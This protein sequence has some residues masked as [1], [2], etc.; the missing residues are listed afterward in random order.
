[1]HTLTIG[2]SLPKRALYEQIAREAAAL[3]DGESDAIANFANLAA[4]LYHSLPDVNWAG[5]YL[6]K[7]DTLIVGPFQG[8]PACVRIP[9]GK[10]VC[11]MAAAQGRTIVVPNVHE[12]PGHIACDAASRS[13]I[14]VP[15]IQAGTVLG[16]LDIDS[17]RL[18]R[19]DEEDRCG[20]EQ[21]IAMLLA[22]RASEG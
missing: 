4:L 22:H 20:L 2:R 6:L 1:M 12:F 8:L 10:G 13:E 17:P 19:F 9:I 18:A 5:F 11:G 16:V 14:V 3:V 21:L 15:M 7:G